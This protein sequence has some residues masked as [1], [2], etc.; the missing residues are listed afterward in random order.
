MA[1]ND[2]IVMWT[3][4][5]LL[6]AHAADRLYEMGDAFFKENPDFSTGQIIKF[7]TA[8]AKD[9]VGDLV[10]LV[11]HLFTSGKGIR[12]FA[13]RL[14]DILVMLERDNDWI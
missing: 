1:F 6:A 5:E 10:T 8:L 13:D 4:D 14:K 11:K 7:V 3:A 9:H 2:L 12:G